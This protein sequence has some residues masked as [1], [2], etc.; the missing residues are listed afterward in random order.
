VGGVA[1]TAYFEEYKGHDILKLEDVN[2]RKPF[3]VFPSGA[4]C[5][6]SRHASVK[7]AKRS[8]DKRDLVVLTIRRTG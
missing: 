1:V 7:A 3:M 5:G 8:I 4:Q 6:V 2:G